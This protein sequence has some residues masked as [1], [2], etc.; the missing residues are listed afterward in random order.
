MLSSGG[1][2]GRGTLVVW[3]YVGCDEAGDVIALMVRCYLSCGSN[4]RVGTMMLCMLR[5]WRL[6]LYQVMVHFCSIC[7]SLWFGVVVM[8][9]MWGTGGVVHVV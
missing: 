3:C 4:V 2:C 7:Y 9:V 6:Q 1:T 8:L 5:L